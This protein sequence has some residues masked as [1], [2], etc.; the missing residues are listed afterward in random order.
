[1]LLFINLFIVYLGI[2]KLFPYTTILHWQY[3]TLFKKLICGQIIL[4]NNVSGVRL[5]PT[6][7]KATGRQQIDLVEL[8][9]TRSQVPS[10]Y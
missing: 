6:I 9:H 2:N 3:F 7:D 4:T 1:M 10:A 8:P 5:T